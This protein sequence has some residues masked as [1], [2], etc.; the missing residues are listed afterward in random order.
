MKKENVLP[1]KTYHVNVQTKDS[2]DEVEGIIGERMGFEKSYETTDQ[3]E[4]PN[5]I[6]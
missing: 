3:L 4:S 5:E 2:L 1:E 6:I